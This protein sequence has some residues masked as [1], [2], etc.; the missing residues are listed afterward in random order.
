MKKPRAYEVKD[1]M[2][3]ASKEG[4]HLAHMFVKSKTKYWDKVLNE[5]D[6][7]GQTKRFDK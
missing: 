2:D 5:K 4:S 3:E 6:E 7:T 1:M